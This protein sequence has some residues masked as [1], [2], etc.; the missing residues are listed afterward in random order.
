MKLQKH[1]NQTNKVDILIQHLYIHV[2]MLSFRGGTVIQ[3]VCFRFSVTFSTYCHFMILVC[4]T[5]SIKRNLFMASVNEKNNHSI[6]NCCSLVFIRATDRQRC[7]YSE[8]VFCRSLN[9]FFHKADKLSCCLL[10]K[11]GLTVSKQ[12]RNVFP[13]QPLRL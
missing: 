10:L 2:Y 7:R 12:Q 1:I 9:C 6:K 4:S 5:C 3:R 13:M 8:Q 11:W